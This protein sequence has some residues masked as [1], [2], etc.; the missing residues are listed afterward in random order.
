M[1]KSN[2]EDSVVYNTTTIGNTGGT[3]YTSINFNNTK[4]DFSITLTPDTF[5]WKN[6]IQ[7]YWSAIGSEKTEEEFLKPKK[8][9]KLKKHNGKNLLS[10]DL[11]KCKES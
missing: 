1:S 10:K 8:V 7:P 5:G 3:A 11:F 2:I 9:A 4:Y 6:H